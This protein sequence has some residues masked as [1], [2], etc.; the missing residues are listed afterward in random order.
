MDIVGVA[1]DVAS[2]L[3]AGKIDVAMAAG[4]WLRRTRNRE[5][6]LRD[7]YVGICGSKKRYDLANYAGALKGHKFCWWRRRGLPNLCSGE[8]RERNTLLLLRDNCALVVGNRGGS[9]VSAAERHPANPEPQS[10]RSA[11]AAAASPSYGLAVSRRRNVSSQSLSF[12][13]QRFPT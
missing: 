11:G 8:H 12:G 7:R 13:L 5:P 9:T 10:E 2:D 6:L 1:E 3:A 4:W